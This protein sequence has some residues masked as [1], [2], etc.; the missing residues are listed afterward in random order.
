MAGITNGDLQDVFNHELCHYPPAVFEPVNALQP[1]TKS[2]LADALWCS[3]VANLPSPSSAVQYVLDGGARLQHIP[4]SRGAT[5]NQIFEQYTMNVIRKYIW[6][7][8][9]CV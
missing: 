8:N 2:S 3:E 7:C 6:Q 1:A 9:Y 4:R 5:Y